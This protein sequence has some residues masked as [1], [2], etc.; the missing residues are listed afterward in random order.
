MFTILYQVTWT[1]RLPEPL[2]F[3]QKCE[4]VWT[5]LRTCCKN[6]VLA[7]FFEVVV[8]SIHS[9]FTDFCK[10]ESCTSVQPNLS[11][12]YL[13][14]HDL[15]FRKIQPC[16]RVDSAGFSLRLTVS[17]SCEVQPPDTWTSKVNNTRKL[18]VV[19]WVII[20]FTNFID[21]S[22]DGPQCKYHLWLGVCSVWCRLTASI[23][24]NFKTISEAE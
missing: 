4:E 8:Q 14:T 21:I 6:Q 11:C 9:W 23:L 1:A 3:K 10:S 15:Q 18:K 16:T 2:W 5:R 7:N 12:S 22:H 19:C 13:I 17:S 24:T 20:L